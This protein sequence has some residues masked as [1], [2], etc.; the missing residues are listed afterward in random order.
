MAGRIA[1]APLRAAG[2]SLG[3][4]ISAM[5][6]GDYRSTMPNA[7]DDDEQFVTLAN[8]QIPRQA[9]YGDRTSEK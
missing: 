2:R 1:L 8:G 3:E 7:P 6:I 4:F 5:G 9:T